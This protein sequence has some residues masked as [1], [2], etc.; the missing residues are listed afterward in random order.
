MVIKE[1]LFF[2]T[3]QI[4]IYF[5]EIDYLIWSSFDFTLDF[6]CAWSGE[7][8]LSK[9]FTPIQFDCNECK[10]LQNIKLYERKYEINVRNVHNKSRFVHFIWF[11]CVLP[12]NNSHKF[13]DNLVIRHLHG[14]HLYATSINLCTPA[15]GLPFPSA[16]LLAVNWQW[17]FF[18]QMS[19]TDCSSVY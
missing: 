17:R 16:G 1:F 11:L 7:G 5:F 19:T 4:F 14:R 3:I 13:G 18:W 9:Q 8:I 15:H 10:K 12:E 6:G 2:E